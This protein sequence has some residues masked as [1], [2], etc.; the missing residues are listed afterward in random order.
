MTTREM[1]DEMASK[2]YWDSNAPTPTN[3]LYSAILREITRKGE[4]SRFAKA[5]RGKFA[6]KG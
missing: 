3:T 5:G 6:L 1:F 2:G 4:A